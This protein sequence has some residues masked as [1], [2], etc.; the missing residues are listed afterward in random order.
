MYVM[1]FDYGTKWIG[2]AIGQRLTATATPLTIVS[3]KN[4]QIDWAHIT[5]LIQEWQPDM[6]VVG[7]PKKDDGSDNIITDSVRRFSRQLDGRYHLPVIMIDEAL[8]SLAARVRF[9]EQGNRFNEK[10]NL[11]DL[12][13]QIILETW[14]TECHP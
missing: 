14:F 7:L 10:R 4:R 8:S 2:V 13:A 12:A 3:V 1:G 5:A 9:T 11:D 6:F